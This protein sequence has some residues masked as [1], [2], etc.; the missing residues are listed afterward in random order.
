MIRF[1]RCSR[2][3]VLLGTREPF[4]ALARNRDQHTTKGVRK[5]ASYAREK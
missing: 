5:A 4:V 1:L 3:H 2:S